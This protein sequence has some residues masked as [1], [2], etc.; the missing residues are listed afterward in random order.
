[1]FP[2]QN[3]VQEVEPV[4]Q[5]FFY[6]QDLPRPSALICARHILLLALTFCTT[7][8]AGTL[9]PFGPVNDFVVGSDPQTFDETVAFFLSLPE[10][11]IGV[12]G[13]AIELLFTNSYVLTY[14]LEFSLSL[15]LILVSHEMGHYIACRIYKVEATLPFFIPTPPMIGPAGTFGAFIRI[16]SPM[17][18]RKAVFDIGVAGPIAGFVMMLPIAIIGISQMEMT[19]SQPVSTGGQLVFG[20]PLIMQLVGL[21]FGKDLAFGVGNAFYY[22]AW[23]GALVTAINLIPSGQLDGGHAVYAALGERVH[24]WTGR[25][26]FPVMAVISVLGAYFYSS[27]SGF[28]IAV[29]LGFM[30][31]VGH[32]RP[33]DQTP[34]D[35]KRKAVAILTLLIFILTFLPF[36]VKL[37]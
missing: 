2:L 16:K 15:L 33:Y 6:G 11:Y 32:P 5:D 26:A 12:I 35:P 14:G 9:Y 25:I 21:A 23:I 17:P 8:I 13:H 4:N 27:P 36:P 31:K 10:K 34:L 7:T 29:I 37:V 30:L 20:D 22:A 24:Y 19:A 1:M 18:S 28:L 3:Q